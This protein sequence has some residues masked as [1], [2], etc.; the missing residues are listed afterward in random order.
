MS[1]L[2]IASRYPVFFLLP[3]FLNILWMRRLRAKNYNSGVYNG[4]IFVLRAAIFSMGA[5]VVFSSLLTILASEDD[6][7]LLVIRYVFGV[8]IFFWGAFVVIGAF[9]MSGKKVV[10]MMNSFTAGPRDIK[11]F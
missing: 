1:F 8:P 9:L 6:K 7:L 4:N 2:D 11:L 5:I 3:I 10:K